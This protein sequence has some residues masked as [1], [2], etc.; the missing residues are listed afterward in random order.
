P[1]KISVDGY[2]DLPTRGRWSCISDLFPRTRM[3]LV[4][5][6]QQ[7]L[8]VYFGVDLGGGEACVAEQFLDGAQVAACCQKMSGKAVAKRVGGDGIGQVEA[9][10]QMGDEARDE[11]RVDAATACADKQRVLCSQTERDKREICVDRVAR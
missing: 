7:V 11:P 2:C 1:P 8:V 5:N 9:A 3:G 6:V 10:A 4:V